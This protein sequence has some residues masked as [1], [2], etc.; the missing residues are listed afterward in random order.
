MTN[1]KTPRYRIEF[2]NNDISKKLQFVLEGVNADG[3][4]IRIVKLIE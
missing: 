3:K 4:M 2:Y 1:K